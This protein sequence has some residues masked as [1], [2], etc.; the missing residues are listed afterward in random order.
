[1]KNTVKKKIK[2]NRIRE[3]V[4]KMFKVDYFYVPEDQK[5]IYIEIIH[6]FTPVSA[7]FWDSWDECNNGE[8]RIKAELEDF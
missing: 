8:N 2:D 1:M 4:S 5:Y 6:E 7:V 3:L